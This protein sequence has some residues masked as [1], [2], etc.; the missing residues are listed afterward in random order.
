MLDAA[1]NRH[2]IANRP[3][4]VIPAEQAE[5]IEKRPTK[6]HEF[7]RLSTS[8]RGD[9]RWE[10]AGHGGILTGSSCVRKQNARESFGLFC[11]TPLW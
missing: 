3:E 1:L 10:A 9:G 4:H 2:F 11:S 7:F 5:K 6:R 8:K